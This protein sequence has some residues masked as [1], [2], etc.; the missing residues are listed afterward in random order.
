MADIL[1]PV[2]VRV[3]LVPILILLAGIITFFVAPLAVEL[4]WMILAS[5]LFAA[6]LV[7]LL[8]WRQAQR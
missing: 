8:L 5:D 7:G 1:A 3:Y 2:N 6:V 4:R